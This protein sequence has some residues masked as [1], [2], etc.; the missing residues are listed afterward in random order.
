[1]TNRIKAFTLL[2][3]A[4]RSGEYKQGAG[5]LFN[6]SNNSYCCLGVLCDVIEKNGLSAEHPHL[7]WAGGNAETDELLPREWAE[8]FQFPEKRQMAYAEKN[9]GEGVHAH[10]FRDIADLLE[11]EF[12]GIP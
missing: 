11:N 12:I 5:K 2:V 8:E 6:L 4:L 1:M 7:Q 9:D 10:S 3:A